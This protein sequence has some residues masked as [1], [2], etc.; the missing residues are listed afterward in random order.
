MIVRG[1]SSSINRPLC[2][3]A[4]AKAIQ[5]CPII[6]LFEEAV[7]VEAVATMDLLPPSVPTCLQISTMKDCS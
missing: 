7:V 4:D 5:F 1:W 6:V 2:L 3:L